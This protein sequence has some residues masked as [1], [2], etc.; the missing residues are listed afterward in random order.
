MIIQMDLEVIIMGLFVMQKQGIA[1]VIVE[2]CFGDN[3][4]DYN[5]Y[6]S[7]ED[8]LQRLGIADATGIANAYGLKKT[9]LQSS[10]IIQK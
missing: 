3:A 9:P 1:A 2:H 10:Q 5:N 6:L 8:K 7:S 4:T